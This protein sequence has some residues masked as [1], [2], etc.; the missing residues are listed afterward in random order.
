M[1]INDKCA[2]CKHFSAESN[3]CRRRAPQVF[4]AG[5]SEEMR[6]LIVTAFPQVDKTGWCSEFDVKLNVLSA[7]H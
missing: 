2:E 3:T 7:P 4:V 1:N 6:P 5:L